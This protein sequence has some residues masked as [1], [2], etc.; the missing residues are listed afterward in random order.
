VLWVQW[1]DWR[2]PADDVRDLGGQGLELVG[3]DL[4]EAGRDK[5]VIPDGAGPVTESHDNDGKIDGAQH[6]TSAQS[7]HRPPG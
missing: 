7:V 3:H 4:A 5:R 1:N 2:H 6:A